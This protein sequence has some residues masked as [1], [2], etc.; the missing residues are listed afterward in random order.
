MLAIDYLS[1]LLLHFEERNAIKGVHLDNNCNISHLLLANDI[2]IFVED[3][4]T[5]I[6]N[7]LVALTFFELASGLKFNMSKSI[8]SSVNVFVDRADS[9]ANLCSLITQFL[10][11]NYLG[12]PLGGKLNFKSFWNQTINSIH[13][14]LNG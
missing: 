2:L 4:D 3:N 1:R 6:K 10:P 5:Y 13:K 12:V 14:K 7:L 9:V 11:V 8:I